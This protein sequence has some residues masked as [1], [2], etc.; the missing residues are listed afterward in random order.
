M[1]SFNPRRTLTRPFRIKSLNITHLGHV[2]LEDGLVPLVLV[3]QLGQVWEVVAL[4]DAA[5]R[6]RRAS[7]AMRVCNFEV[8]E[9]AST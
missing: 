6:L 5:Q 2:A 3:A 1:I 4:D 7:E 9:R 8:K